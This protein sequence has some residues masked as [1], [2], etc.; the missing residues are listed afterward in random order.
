MPPR[1]FDTLMWARAVEM[2]ERAE[3]LQ[4]QFFRPEPRRRCVWEPPADVFET[5]DA[6]LIVVALPGV[7]ADG[8]S[9]E[10]GDG[11]LS[12]R[13]ERRLPAGIADGIVHRLE[14]PH[15][16]FERRIL[17]P[18]STCELGRPEL[19]DGCLYIPLRKR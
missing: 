2:L 12:V 11:Q 5:A 19:V 8:I 1:D 9:V 4:R 13:G 15:G 3:R 10:L 7:A 6:F 16:T 17:L 18:R 14:I